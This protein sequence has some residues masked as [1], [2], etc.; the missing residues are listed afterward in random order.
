PRTAGRGTPP[1]AGDV[2]GR[3]REPERGPGDGPVAVECAREPGVRDPGEGGPRRV[4]DLGGRERG[5]GGGAVVRP[6][7]PA[8]APAAGPAGP[9][10]VQHA[11]GVDAAQPRPRPGGAG[12]WAD[13]GGA[14]G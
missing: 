9:G 12:Q 8:G 10:A 14:A 2:G 5:A 6:D 7:R 1:A 11:P 4:A 3:G 13:R